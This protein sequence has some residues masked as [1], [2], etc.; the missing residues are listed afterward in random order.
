MRMFVLN[1]FMLRGEIVYESIFAL[2][3]F[4][5]VVGSML[6]ETAR[7][8]GSN[9]VASLLMLTAVSKPFMIGM[10][11]SKMMRSKFCFTISSHA[12]KPD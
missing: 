1:Q 3:H 7:M 9:L 12:K 8:K 10:H 6:A 5:T 11:R 4:W 2:L